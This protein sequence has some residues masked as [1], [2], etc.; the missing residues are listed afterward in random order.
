MADK[1]MDILKNVKGGAKRCLH[2]KEIKK[3]F[4]IWFNRMWF[5]YKGVTFGKNMQVYDKFYLRK[6]RSG[7]VT[8][9][10][11]FVFSSGSCYNPLCRNVRG[12]IALHEGAKVTIGNNVS[13]SSTCVRSNISITIGD[14]VNIGGDCILL[15]TDS[16][17]LDWRVRRDKARD[18]RTA[19][20]RP[21]VIGDDVLIGARSIILK[22]VT[23]GARSVIGSGSVVTKDIPADCIAA[24]NPAKVIRQIKQ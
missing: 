21:I 24:G 20:N 9:G 4:W 14:N 7:T 10:D 12:C 18:V 22:G 16:H 6:A 13:M 11:N 2:P 19:N 17:N 3:R 15:D 23:I 5:R 1:S 8:I